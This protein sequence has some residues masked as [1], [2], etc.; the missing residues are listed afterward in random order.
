MNL[1]ASH[2]SSHRQLYFSMTEGPL[3]TDALAHSWLRDLCKYAFPPLSL[4]TQTLCKLREDVEQVLLVVP[5]WSTRTMVSRTHPPCD[6]TSLAHSSEKGP[7]LSAAWHH[8]APA[9]RSVEPPCVAPGRDAADLSG[10]PPAVV[11]TITQARALSTR[12]TYALKW[13][14]FTN[15]SRTGVL[16]AEKTPEDARLE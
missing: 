8:M 13:S 11:E 9:S 15:C 10:L 14:L 7:P 6:S 3:G 5:L 1:F 16:L 4:L 12:Q 2:E